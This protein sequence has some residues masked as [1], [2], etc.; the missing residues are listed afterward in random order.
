MLETGQPLHIHD[1]DKITSKEIIVRQAFEKEE[2]TIL[3]GKTFS[4]NAEDVVISANQKLIS[5]AG[6]SGSKTTAINNQTTNILIESAKF[7][8]SSIKKTSRRLAIF[9]QASQ[10]FAKSFNLPFGDYALYRAI[11]LIKEICPGENEL[12]IC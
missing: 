10:Y 1:Y 9:T 3:S 7:S 4:L 6:I 12:I 8:P 2:I 5:L 11:E